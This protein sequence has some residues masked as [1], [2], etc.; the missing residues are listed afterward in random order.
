MKMSR[1]IFPMI[2]LFM[3]LL[4][5][6]LLTEAQD[7][8]K[9]LGNICYILDS[10][11]LLGKPPAGVRIGVMSFGTGRF[12]LSGVLAGIIPINGSAFIGQN[13]TIVISL[14]YSFDSG[15]S[16]ESGSLSSSFSVIYMVVD[17]QTLKGTHTTM[18]VQTTP[19]P[20]SIKT[21]RGGMRLF[22]CN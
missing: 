19:E 9:Y 11:E 3:I 16:L 4:L 2:A 21:Q 6:P 5:F 10:D 20:L 12:I 22:L 13:N 1:C 15:G 14:Y 17:A 8:V 7:D 18:I